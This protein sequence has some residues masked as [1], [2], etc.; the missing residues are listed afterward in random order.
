MIMESELFHSS[1]HTLSDLEIEKRRIFDLSAKELEL[2]KREETLK[3]QQKELEAKAE[4]VNLMLLQFIEKK[5]KFQES[6][7]GS[8]YALNTN[9]NFEMNYLGENLNS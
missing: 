8:G 7:E 9:E 5:E 1:G 2:E 6:N 4:E 3:I